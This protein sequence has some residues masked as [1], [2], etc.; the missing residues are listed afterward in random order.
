M[1]LEQRPTTVDPTQ[2]DAGITMKITMQAVKEYS[3]NPMMASISRAC[4]LDKRILAAAC[5]HTKT[6][7]QGELSVTLL[8]QRLADYFTAV[9]VNLRAAPTAP[10][11][12]AAHSAPPN[13]RP[14]SIPA[15]PPIGQFFEAVER[16][17]DQGL[18]KE[19]TGFNQGRT[20]KTSGAGPGA[21]LIG[22]R[23][24]VV[25]MRAEMSDVI[26]AIKDD[27]KLHLRYYIGGG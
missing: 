11:A 22:A 2:P 19:V 24:S 20:Y 12:P 18:L 5:K 27:P 26:A 16:L 23:H 13:P 1:Y 14:L 17:L 4:L 6:T 25:A 3:E 21:E 15:L 8:W 9:E 10:T 7:G